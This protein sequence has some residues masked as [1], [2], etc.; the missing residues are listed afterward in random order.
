M[1]YG[2]VD[3]PHSSLSVLTN[4]E[5]FLFYFG[6]Y[7][8]GKWKEADENNISF[9]ETKTIT[10]PISFYGKLNKNLPE[11]NTNV[12]GLARAHS[13]INFPKDTVATK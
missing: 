5:F 13:F 10:S 9:T 1:H 6:G 3:M 8:T 11:L 12:Y 4:N 7:K 2:G